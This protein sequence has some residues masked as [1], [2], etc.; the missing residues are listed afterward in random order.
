MQTKLNM[1]TAQICHLAWHMP[2]AVKLSFTRNWPQVQGDSKAGCVHCPVSRRLSPTAACML[3]HAASPSGHCAAAFNDREQCIYPGKQLCSQNLI[4]LWVSKP[5]KRNR[6]HSND[7]AHAS[8]WLRTVKCATNVLV[9]IP[10]HAYWCTLGLPTRS[11]SSKKSSVQDQTHNHNY[12]W[13]F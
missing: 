1:K 3:W 11:S 9:W 2:Q 8:Y 6:R 4:Q 10:Q 7:T 13:M 12:T 5:N